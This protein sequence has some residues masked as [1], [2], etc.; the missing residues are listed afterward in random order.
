MAKTNFF[1]VFEGRAGSGLLR[2]ILNSSPR[3][4]FE[5][6]W[7]MFNLLKEEGPGPRQ[8]QQIGRF[9]GETEYRALDALGFAN[10]LSDIVD[11]EGFASEL[12]AHEV[13]VISL[14]RRNIAKQVV[15]SLNALRSKEITGKVHAYTQKDIVDEPFELDLDQFDAHL[16]RLIKRSA[17]QELFVRQH[18]WESVDVTYE[19]LILEKA[20]T[21]GR[22]TDFLRTPV[23]DVDLKPGE[24]PLKQTPPDLS[25]LLGNFDALQKRYAGTRF[26]AMIEDVSV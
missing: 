18:D 25:L 26:Q 9:Y 1:L 17:A 4:V 12:L 6:E 16:E 20:E 21:I 3:I 13:R 22:I 14:T 15:S 8:V 10:K 7:M 11:P 23:E 19:D 24:T 2:A 5:P